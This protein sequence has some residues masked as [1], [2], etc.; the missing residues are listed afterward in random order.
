MTERYLMQLSQLLD[1]TLTQEPVNAADFR[2]RVRSG[3]WNGATSGAARG[4]VQVNLVVLPASDAADFRRYCQANRKPCP[5]LAISEAGDPTLSM[6]GDGVD[7]RTDLP[8]YR[9][10]VDGEVVDTPTDIRSYWRSD[11]VSFAIGCSFTFEHSLIEHGLSIRHLE[12]GVEAPLYITNIPTVRAGKFHGPL[13]VSMR[14]F[15]ARDAIRAVQITSRFPGVHG[16]PVH[17]G[18]PSLLGIKNIA[19]PDYG[20]AVLIAD[21]ELPVFWAC[22]V[23]PQAVIAQTKPRFCITHYPNHM[24]VTDAK[25]FNY[26][27]L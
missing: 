20:D 24:L 25:N 23:T 6:L 19:K 7:L 26:A 1:N 11:L 18:D 16:A 9:V 27:V 10:F 21:D 12:L 17:I 15:S 2:K 13:V 3:E 14:P 4:F 22:G 8:R 5:L